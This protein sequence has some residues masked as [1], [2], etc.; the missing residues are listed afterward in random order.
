MNR[1]RLLV[2]TAVLAASLALP[3]VLGP[4]AEAALP[5]VGA[6]NEY[7]NGISSGVT[8]ADVAIGSDGSTWFAEQGSSTTGKAGAIGRRTTA[9]VVTKW[10]TVGKPTSMAKGPDN[11]I[12]FTEDKGA[13]STPALAKITSTGTITEYIIGGQTAHL[14]SLVSGTD[15][16]LSFLY[17]DTAGGLPTGNALVMRAT[18]AGTI[19]QLGSGFPT[20]ELIGGFQVPV[21]F[22]ESMTFGPD[23][24][25]WITVSGNGDFVS[26]IV[27]VDVPDGTVTHHQA[28]LS[29]DAFPRGIVNGP[30]GNMWF[31]EGGV[32]KIGRITTAGVITE[33]GTGISAGANPRSIGV[34]YDSA[35][36]FTEPGLSKIGRIETNGFVKEYSAGITASSDFPGTRMPTDAAGGV[37]FA[38]VRP[39]NVP[40]LARI[41]SVST[42]SAPAITAQ[43]AGNGQ[44]TI[45]FIPPTDPGNA[46]VTG[47]SITPYIGGTA[48]TAR[49][50]SG[51]ATTRIVTGL[52]NGTTYTFRVAAVNAYGTGT[53]SAAGAPVTPI[54]PPGAPTLTSV[55]GAKSSAVVTWTAPTSTGGS[56]ITGYIVTPVR[57]GVTQSAITFNDTATTHTISGLT[58]GRSYRFKVAA[59]N[60]PG[61][62]TASALSATVIP[63]FADLTSFVNQQYIDLVGR[64]P[65]TAERS[66]ATT[67][68]G[69]TTTAGTFL[70]DLR[71]G[72]DATVNVDPAVRL[73]FAYFLRTPD[74]GGLKYWVGKRRN[75]T[76]LYTVSQ[77]FAQSSEFKNRYGPL[78]NKAFVELVYQNVLG[79]PGE[80][81]GVNYWTKQLDTKNRTRGEVMVGFSE[82]TEYQR[83]VAPSV[84]FSVLWLDLLGSRPDGPTLDT[85]AA[86]LAAGTKTDA[87][88]AQ[89]LLADPQYVLRF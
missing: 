23:G 64:A 67:A 50:F 53:A 13:G 70:S 25:L 32:D 71:D 44:V 74:P 18:T 33:F 5:P 14:S 20:T 84:D 47:Y 30:D 46:S 63:P 52:T 81:T 40:A 22:P 10:A 6:V 82:S 88:L 75:G 36:W 1:T 66:A 57:D 39:G 4:T 2:G 76:R 11:S 48:Q 16:Y 89:V 68:L 34:G 21:H 60:A 62:G 77:R 58:N 72:E 41:A 31:A 19:T 42:P 49:S 3:A 55:K 38:E 59:K 87:D 8:I 85:W 15:G 83:N 65:S 80:S 28:G 56:A 9:G 29:A 26:E 35:L 45:T 79:R 73:Y 86:E 17:Y 37:W 51:A 7:P 69:A 12:W 54:G 43:T 61:V 78:T 24:D 27:E